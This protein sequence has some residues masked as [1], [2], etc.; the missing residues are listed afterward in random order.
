MYEAAEARAVELERRAAVERDK[1]KAAA[2][3]QDSEQAAALLELHELG[4][5]A[6]DLAALTGVPVKK[7]RAMIKGVKPAAAQAAPAKSVADV[8]PAAAEEPSTATPEPAAA[9]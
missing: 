2:A 4:R 7:V 3:E 9:T 6:E 1:A 8:K 5:N